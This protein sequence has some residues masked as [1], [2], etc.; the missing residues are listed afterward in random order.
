MKRLL[1]ALSS[2]IYKG[3]LVSN[4][5]APL[6]IRYK[7][8]EVEDVKGNLLEDI[9]ITHRVNKASITLTSNSL[10]KCKIKTFEKEWDRIFR[11]RPVMEVDKVKTLHDLCIEKNIEYLYN[12]L[13][14]SK[15]VVQFQDNMFLINKML[16]N[17][18]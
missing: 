8:F 12:D 2:T 16:A 18:R 4:I 10:V 13:L 7:M 6:A 14:S 3:D 9:F 11:R 5:H 17:G 1:Q 15:T